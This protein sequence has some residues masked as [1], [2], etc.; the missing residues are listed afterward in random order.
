MP[1]DHRPPLPVP[2]ATVILV[3]EK[4]GQ[5]Q[6]YLLRRS[7][8]SGFMPGSYVFPGGLVDD[9]DRDDALWLAHAD[10]TPA[11]LSERLGPAAGGVEALCYGVAAV[12]ET[13]EEAGVLLACPRPP[14]EADFGRACERRL[15]QSPAHG[16]FTQLVVSEDW[17]L[18]LSAL[19]RWARWITPERMP[20]RFDTRF[21]VAALP[22][23]QT[24][25][26]DMRET[27]DGIWISP[28][29]ALVENIKR[30]P[31]P[32]PSDSGYPARVSERSQP[33]PAAQRAL[34]PELGPAD[35]APSGSPGA[36]PSIRSAAAVG[37]HVPSE[38]KRDPARG[39]RASP[40]AGG[41][42]VFE[43][44]ALQRPLPAHPMRAKEK[45]TRRE[46]RSRGCFRVTT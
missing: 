36:G 12:R 25:L 18:T 4:A 11:A 45:I 39:C 26:P 42:A 32:E 6:V 31:A 7:R 5:L 24:C 38:R 19:S 43:G 8:T 15:S 13:F 22:P 40:A 41:G 37:S 20:R 10:L 3:R 1:A 29:A 21:F 33:S 16:W 34:R 2:A 35:H 46:A 27:T 44:L 30:Q 17:V 14:A 23:G 28:R 9:G